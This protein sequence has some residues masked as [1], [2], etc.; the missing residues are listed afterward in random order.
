MKSITEVSQVCLSMCDLFVFSCLSMCDLFVEIK[1][2]K[3]H[4]SL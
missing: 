3:I 4:K 2:I 1:I